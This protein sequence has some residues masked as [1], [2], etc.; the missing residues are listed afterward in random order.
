VGTA[1]PVNVTA[2]IDGDEIR[3]TYAAFNCT[4]PETGNFT[5]TLQ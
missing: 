1:C 3:G 4:V 5:L 2:T